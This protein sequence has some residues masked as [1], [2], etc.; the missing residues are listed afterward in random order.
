M[1][2]SMRVYRFIAKLIIVIAAVVLA[3]VLAFV[4]LQV[5]GRERLYS[6]G[7]T[8]GPDLTL[9]HIEQEE[10]TSVD[11]NMTADDWEEGD[12]RYQGIHYR[13][14]SD[15][16]TFLFM[17]IDKNT[18]VAQAEN[19][20]DGGQADALFLL[21]L[22]PVQKDISV[23]AINRNTMTNVAVYD[24]NGRYVTDMTLQICLQHGY[25]DGAASSCERTRDA[26]SGLF[27]S[28]PINGYCAVNMAAIPLIN[29]AV[30]GVE[31]TAIEDVPGSSIKEG[32]TLT[33]MGNDAYAYLHNRDTK[34]FASADRRLER[35]KQYMTAYISKAGEAM[36]SSLTLP[37]TLYNT[38]RNYMVTDIQ[39]DE[40]TYLASQASG[41]SFNRESFYSVAGETVMGERF[42]EYYADETALYE[43]ILEVFYYEVE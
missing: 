15:I 40:V 6:S 7:N 37:I 41:Y 35:Q 8:T 39:L 30:G 18:E 9:A 12:I 10:T 27:Y 11:D 25:G 17:G 16:L 33:L 29:D 19:G 31:I 32:D 23:I 28:L 21:V 4:I 3:G 5:R 43:L 34:S 26:V 42:E 1:K 22:N 20:T 13:Y 36:K 14:N 2:I 38:I 24:D